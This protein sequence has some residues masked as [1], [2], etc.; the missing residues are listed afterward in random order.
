M[1]KQFLFT[2][3][4][5]V[6]TIT[7]NAQLYLP[8]NTHYS[9]NNSFIGIGPGNSFP[10]ANLHIKGPANSIPNFKLEQVYDGGP[11]GYGYYNFS[12][13]NYILSLSCGI[14]YPGTSALPEK[15]LANFSYNDGMSVEKFLDINN[16]SFFLDPSSTAKSLS[17]AGNINDKIFFK[18]GNVGIGT[19]NPSALLTVNGKIEA[20]DIEVKNVAADFVFAP[21]YKLASLEEVELYIKANGHLPGVA[22]AEETAKGVELGK[23][24]T[25]LLQKIEELT[26]YTIELQKRVAELEA[27]NQE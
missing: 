21:D 25:L 4:I 16:I 17:I 6:F 19:Q 13:N 24:N 15:L 5:L 8:G 22:P 3:L 9:S 18:S 20:K 12:V 26:L 2:T 11:T 23:F 7:L 27:R 10:S 14:Q 1:N